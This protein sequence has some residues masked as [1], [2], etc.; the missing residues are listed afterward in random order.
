M[1]NRI[2]LHLGSNAQSRFPTQNSEVEYERNSEV[3]YVRNS[4]WECVQ[5]MTMLTIR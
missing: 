3:E 5:L 4:E 2:F 1:L